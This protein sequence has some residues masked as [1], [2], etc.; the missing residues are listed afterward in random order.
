M[1]EPTHVPDPWSTLR[2]HTAARIALGRSGGSLPTREV[3]D[4][5]L[6]HAE[7]RDAVHAELD[8]QSLR[9]QLSQRG[10]ESI[11][12]NTLADNRHVYLQRPDLGRRLQ[13]SSRDR[14]IA[15]AGTGTDVA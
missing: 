12:V 9:Q 14:L 7:A 13:D 15:I 10:H 2:Q 5:A 4:F 11:E 1:S 6:A 3:V 8:V